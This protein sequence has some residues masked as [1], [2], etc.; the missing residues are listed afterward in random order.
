MKPVLF[1]EVQRFRHVPWVM[2]LVF[3]LAAVPW[4][5]FWQQIVRGVP[6]GNNPGPDLLVILIWLAF[7][8]GLPLFFWQLK[9][10]VEVTPDAVVI[11]YAPFVNRI[12]PRATIAH[13]GTRRYR[14]LREF[15]GW[16]VRGWGGRIAYNVSG[17]EGAELTLTD[18]RVVLIGSRQAAALIQA[19][20]S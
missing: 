18:G 12:I 6:F 11:R 20:R 15:G 13:A 1:R 3:G 16:G 14:P 19:I 9:L 17:N 5:G 7:G 8:I 2:A 10:V 4:W